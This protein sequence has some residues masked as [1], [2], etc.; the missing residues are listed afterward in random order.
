[1]KL[2]TLTFLLAF[3]IGFA[4]KDIYSAQLSAKEQL[5]LQSYFHENFGIKP[6]SLSLI[7]INY[8][9][10][11]S[12]CHYD[13]Y[14]HDPYKSISWFE[15]YYS[16]NNIIFPNNTEKIFSFYDDKYAAKWNKRPYAY[17]KN[18]VL[19]NLIRSVKNIK[20]CQCYLI[21]SPEGKVMIKYGEAR[22]E[23]IKY[24][25]NEITK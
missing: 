15:K 16:D 25:L 22:P 23:D 6:E 18:H 21:L 19:H 20:T 7:I 13:N 5:K 17:D 12:Y 9:Q 24:M 1:M 8:N 4:Q 2:I 10:P 11:K 14:D 3:N